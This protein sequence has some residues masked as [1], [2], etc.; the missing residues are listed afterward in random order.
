MYA[1]FNGFRFHFIDPPSSNLFCQQCENLAYEPH[2]CS[3]CKSLFCKQCILYSACPDCLQ[4]SESIPDDRSNKLIQNLRVWCPNS[5]ASGLGCNWKGQL[6]EVPGHQNECPREK[7]SC[8]YSEVGCEEKMYRSK[9][10]EHEREN[11]ETH[12]N[13]AMK[14]VIS[15]STT[16][17]ELQESVEQLKVAVQDIKEH[18]V[19]HD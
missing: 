4:V 11:R 10:E 3:D 19:I 6:R 16:V 7:V 17:K 5:V 12:L 8:S 18:A 15:L 13:L 2:L 9:L 1:L 14:K